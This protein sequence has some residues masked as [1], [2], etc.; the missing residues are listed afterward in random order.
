MITFQGFKPSGMQKIADSMGFQGNMQDFQKFLQ[1]NPDRQ[2]EMMRYQD[3]A[4]KMVEGGYVK[5]M[6]KGGTNIR[7]ITRDRI[8]SPKIPAGAKVTPYG[9]PTKPPSTILRAMS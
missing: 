6:K 8:T 7:D 1:D 3:M 5:K 9:I 2:S 4:R